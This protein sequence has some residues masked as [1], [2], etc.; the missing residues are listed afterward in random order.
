[1]P[2]ATLEDR[3]FAMACYLT[4]LALGETIKWQHVGYET[5][6]G[7]FAAYERLF[8]ERK[9]KGPDGKQIPIPYRFKQDYIDI[10]LTALK[11]YEGVKDRRNMIS[12]H[13]VRLLHKHSRKHPEHSLPRAL[14]DWIILGRY[15][16]ARRGE[17]CQT[18]QT[19]YRR[20]RDTLPCWPTDEA[21]AFI[22]ADFVFLDHRGAVLSARDARRGKKVHYVT[23]EWCYQKNG[24]HG[25][26][27]TFA[28][29][30][31][32]KVSAQCSRLFESSTAPTSSKPL[33][34]TPWPST[35]MPTDAASSSQ[36]RTSQTV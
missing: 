32:N 23:I 8:Q 9:I 4:S 3:N 28:L 11:R 34:T 30:R 20:T 29:D 19:T 21:Q 35:G 16:G 36:N 7:Y 1:M 17:W 27:I 31:F 14:L 2:E 18:T 12:D 15:N 22:A 13:M 26:K 24:E 25:Q 10:I 33:L 6:V 5:I